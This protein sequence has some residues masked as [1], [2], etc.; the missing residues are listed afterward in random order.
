MA[1]CAF[2]GQEM[3][4]ALQECADSGAATVQRPCAT[5]SSILYTSLGRGIY[6]GEIG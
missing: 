2:G 4:Q 6:P 1:I 5:L 3:L